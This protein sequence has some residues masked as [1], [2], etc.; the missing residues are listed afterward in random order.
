MAEHGGNLDEAAQLYGKQRADMVDLSTGISPIAYDCALGSSRQFQPLPFAS[1]LARLYEAARVCYQIDKAAAICAG[2]GSQQLLAHLPR[3]FRTPQSVWCPGPTYNEHGY[4]WQKEGHHVTDSQQLDQE[5]SVIIL[6]QP[7]NP[8]GRIWGLDEVMAAYDQV[9]RKQGL[10]VIDEAFIDALDQ[11]A[12]F[13]STTLAG[14]DHVVVLRSLGKFYGL[15]GLRVGFAISGSGLIKRLA[16][17]L[18][19]W[20][21]SQPAIDVAI[22]ALRDDAWQKAH[23]AWL[24]Q[25]ANWLADLLAQKGFSIT[26][27]V[28][29]F[30]T[31]TDARVPAFHESLAKAGFWTRI[32]AQHPEMMRLGLMTE[33]DEAAFAKLVAA[34]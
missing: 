32:Y 25:K 31:I 23:K 22:T 4:R 3:L 21:V 33:K 11:T 15:A 27:K 30:V 10:L 20:P 29:L 2:A 13:A 5:A 18:G 12:S 14:D 34:F 6:G 7:N 28:P 16:D 26:A 17:D 1:D 24:C 8:T 19:P 9:R